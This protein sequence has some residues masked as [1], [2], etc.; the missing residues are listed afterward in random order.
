MTLNDGT[1]WLDTATFLMLLV[2]R[3]DIELLLRCVVAVLILA[4]AKLAK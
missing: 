1:D 3:L 2:L 4:A